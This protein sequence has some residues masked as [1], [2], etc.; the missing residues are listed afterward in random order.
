MG[1]FMKNKRGDVPVTILVIGVFV[2]CGLA[3]G[4]FVYSSVLMNK[5]FEGVD[6]VGKANVEIERDSLDYYHYQAN[7]TKFSFNLDF[8]F[9][10]EV[11][12]FS[13]EYFGG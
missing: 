1:L 11:P 3:I 6:L 9:F 13:I 4:S 2:V 5:S 7:K 8:D 10:K 12:T